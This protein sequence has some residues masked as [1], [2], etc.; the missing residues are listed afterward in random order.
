MSDFRNDPNVAQ[1]E[2]FDLSGLM[3]SYLSNWKWFVISIVGCVLIA[4]IYAATVVPS[5]NVTAS[6]YMR[7]DQF[8]QPGTFSMDQVNPMAAF[9]GGIDETE[10]EVLKS[11]NNLVKVVDSLNL[12][13]SYAQKGFLRNTPLYLNNPV[14]ASMDTAALADL[15][16]PVDIKVI[17]E[18]DGLYTVKMRIT[19]KTGKEKKTFEDVKLP[20]TLSTPVGKLTLT[21]TPFASDFDGTELINIQSPMARAKAL[22]K[23]LSLDF[24]QNSEKIMRISMLTPIPAYGTAVINCMVAVYNENLVHDKN[25]SAVQTENFIHERLAMLSNE[26]KDVE[27]RLQKYRQAH[28]ITNIEAQ[29]ALNLQSKSQLEQELADIQAQSALLSE[30]ERSIAGTD[31]YDVVPLMLDNAAINASLE[32]YNTRVRNYYRLSDGV[33]KDSPMTQ[34]LTEELKRDK[35]KIAAAIDNARKGLNA[36]R[37][38]VASLDRE[39][40]GELASTPAIDKGLQEI[41]REQQVKVNIYTFLLQRGEEIAL[42]KTMAVNTARLIDNPTSDGIPVA[43]KKGLIYGLGFIFGLIIPAAVLFARRQLFPVFRDQNE[44]ERLTNIPFLGEICKD[45][46]AG[47]NGKNCIVVGE[48]VATPASELFRLLRNN[49]SFTRAGKDAK[50]ILITSCVSGEGKT[51]VAANLAAT[52]ALADK[53]V[54]V[55]GM[56]LRRPFLAHEMGLSNQRGITTYLS[57]NADSIKDLIVQSKIN[58]NLYVLPAGPVPPSPNELLMSDRLDTMM[59]TLRDN[60]DYVIIDSAPIG[61]ISDTFLITKYS[62]IQIYVTR[63]NYSRRSSLKTLKDA[64]ETGKFT[65]PFVILNGVDM[66]SASYTFRK[67]GRYGHSYGYGY[68][69]K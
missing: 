45:S 27:N 69:K 13:Y 64:V 37:R 67:Y 65:A 23:S 55:I 53:K 52:Y 33:S 26:V 49:I 28:N 54:I 21:A 46:D 6:L 40:R 2:S 1:E 18:G 48:H 63:A 4:V 16:A 9:T 68:T 3:L 60:Y 41:F 29:T 61:M 35:V 36:R 66:S 32:A 51:F 38:S 62:D 47:K 30:I 14:N 11:R 58:P 56:D 12:C 10:L 43:P 25:L 50:V 5:Y 39:S 22:S 31:T 7:D 44:L 34:R 15:Q 42:Q 17:A 20:A 59:T 19:N 24:A 57:G 8:K